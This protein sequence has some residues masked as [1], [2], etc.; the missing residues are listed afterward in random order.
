[1]KTSFILIILLLCAAALKNLSIFNV[2]KYICEEGAPPALEIDKLCGCI[3]V[4]LLED[5]VFGRVRVAYRFPETMK[6]VEFVYWDPKEEYPQGK[7]VKWRK[8]DK[9]MT[10]TKNFV[11]GNGLIFVLKDSIRLVCQNNGS[12]NGNLYRINVSSVEEWVSRN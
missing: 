1:M 8:L 12:F 5:S 11:S 7:F 3:W 2:P 4:G 10:I 9:P 6:F